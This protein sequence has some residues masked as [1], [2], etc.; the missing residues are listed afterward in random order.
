MRLVL[1]RPERVASTKDEL[2]WTTMREMAL[3]KIPSAPH[4]RRRSAQPSAEDRSGAKHLLGRRH[5]CALAQLQRHPTSRASTRNKPHCWQ[6]LR[7]TS[8]NRN[9]RIAPTARV[10]DG[11]CLAAAVFFMRHRRWQ[12]GS[13]NP[14]RLLVFRSSQMIQFTRLSA[15]QRAVS[16][17]SD[18]TRWA[19]ARSPAARRKRCSG[20]FFSVRNG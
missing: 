2:C 4:T 12:A 17:R 11:S 10:A 19:N 3:P 5:S 18:V 16:G 9:G 7:V 6:V 14:E 1:P 15:A 20:R 13:L 8:Q